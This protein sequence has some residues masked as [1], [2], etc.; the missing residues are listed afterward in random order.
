MIK[1]LKVLF[2]LLWF[3]SVYYVHFGSLQSYL[4]HS[5]NFGHVRSIRFI[6]L[7]F[8][9]FSLLRSYTVDIGPI[10][11]YSVHYIHF[12]HNLSI[13]SYLVHFSP[14]RSTFFLFGPLLSICIHSGLFIPLWSFFLHLHIGK[15]YVWVESIYYIYIYIYLNQTRNI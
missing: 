11:S 15:E 5:V 3:Y 8:G 6:L 1:Y 2:G 4:G 14:I 7:L 9:P 12:G 10:C 13:R